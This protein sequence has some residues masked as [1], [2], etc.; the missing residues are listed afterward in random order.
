MCGSTLSQNQKVTSHLFCEKPVYNYHHFDYVI[1]VACVVYYRGAAPI[2]VQIYFTQNRSKPEVRADRIIKPRKTCLTSASY[3]GFGDFDFS[4]IIIIISSSS[5]FSFRLFWS[6]N[7]NNV[8][9][10]DS[11]SVPLITM[12]LTTTIKN[13]D[14]LLIINSKQWSPIRL[15]EC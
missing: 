14:N 1:N 8:N 11:D 13:C 3:F 7:I 15:P 10:S 6:R 4:V 12:I 5:S 2:I 9:D